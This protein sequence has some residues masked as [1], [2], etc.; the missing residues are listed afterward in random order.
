MRDAHQSLLATRFRT[1]DLLQVAKPT[2]EYMKDLF[3]L[4]MWGGATFDV[5]YRFLNESPWIRLQKLRKEIPDIMFQMLFR[6]S[7]GV[8]YTNYPDNVIKEFLK[9]NP[10]YICEEHTIE[11][12]EKQD[13]FFI[14]K[15]IKK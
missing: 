13:G 9:E 7:N 2:N 1:Y 6:A 11:P 14:A 12:T 4:E 5:A 10:T 8:G 3:S 15:L